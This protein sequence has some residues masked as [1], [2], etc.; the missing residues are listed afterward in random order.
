MTRVILPILALGLVAGC[1]WMPFKGAFKSAAVV[2]EPAMR[3][4]EP[5]GANGFRQVVGR[6]I[7]DVTVPASRNVRIIGPHTAMTMDHRPN[8]L[9]F[10]VDGRGKVLAVHCG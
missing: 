10:D 4:E 3:P 5:C 6:Q 8:R 1:G 7:G 2:E 9:N